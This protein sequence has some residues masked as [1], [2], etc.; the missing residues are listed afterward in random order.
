MQYFRL[1]IMCTHFG[2]EV[3]KFSRDLKVS[4]FVTWATSGSVTW[5]K[6]KET[7]QQSI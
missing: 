4:S 2:L 5:G 1:I 6:K 7:V 3:G